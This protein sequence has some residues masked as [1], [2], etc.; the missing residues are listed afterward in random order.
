MKELTIKKEDKKAVIWKQ[1]L[2]VGGY[3]EDANQKRTAIITECNLDN[4]L[5]IFFN[6]YSEK[7]GLDFFSNNKE[8]KGNNITSLKSA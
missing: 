3:V 4:Y 5:E 1:K 7:T 6:R 2:L 8:A